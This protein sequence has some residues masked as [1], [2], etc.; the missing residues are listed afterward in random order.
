MAFLPEVVIEVPEA[1]AAASGLLAWI[2]RFGALSGA[3][4]LLSRLFGTHNPEPAT[5]NAMRPVVD[6][7]TYPQR[8]I[9]VLLYHVNHALDRITE[10]LV[11]AE[12]ITRGLVHGEAVRASGQAF[13][14]LHWAQGAV[15]QERVRASGQAFSVLH[16]AQGAVAQE[17]VRAS[18][19]AFSVLHSAQALVRNEAATRHDAVVRAEAKATAQV[20]A[21]GI[22]DRTYAGRL[23]QIEAQAR[24]DALVRQKAAIEA[25]TVQPTRASWPVLLAELGA[26][27]T[28]AGPD[29][30]GLRA[31]IRA[32]PTRAPATLTE[33]AADP[34]TI[35]RVL[36][37]AL[38]ECVIPNCRNLSKAGR[39][40]HG[41]GELLGAAGFL[42]FIAYATAHPV[43]AARDTFDVVSPLTDGVANAVR[44]VVHV[45]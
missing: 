11:R 17:R 37:R 29:L 10:A 26:A 43:E 4:S 31:L 38:T 30:A 9:Y 33:A 21:M 23:V 44:A 20:D 6:L 3:G 24:H 5:G 42:A 40:L 45:G 28:A 34:A 14:V 13:S 2:S 25:E 32:V 15:A 12:R 1:E 18:G 19:Q 41:L 39:D 35:D 27:E 7:L 22:A 16:W 36:L 8:A